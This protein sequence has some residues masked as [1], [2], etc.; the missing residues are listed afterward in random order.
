MALSEMIGAHINSWSEKKNQRVSIDD[1]IDKLL[2]VFAKAREQRNYV[3]KS[4]IA[5]IITA[6]SANYQIT[7]TNYVKFPLPEA[8]EVINSI[9]ANGQE[10]LDSFS[11]K[12]READSLLK[13]EKFSESYDIYS[14][15]SQF[16]K[17]EKIYICCAAI[18]QLM[19]KDKE[20]IDYCERALL[21]NAKSIESLIIL[22]TIY[23][24]AGDNKRALDYLESAYL[25]TSKNGPLLYNLGVL[26]IRLRKTEKAIG[27]FK[28]SILVDNSKSSAYLNLSIC[29]FNKGN[30]DD[31]LSN[32]DMALGI[33][34]G[35]P[36]ALSHK[37]EIQRF[38]GNN[39][40]AIELFKRCLSKEPENFVSLKGLALCNIVEGD[41]IGAAML[42]KLHEN[43]IK[44]SLL[45]TEFS[46]VDIGWT[47]TT[48]IRVLPFDG[49]YLKVVYNELEV[50]VPIPFLLDKIG[51]GLY[52]WGVATYPVIL[53]EYEVDEN[54][55]EACNK[56][57]GDGITKP[58]LL[59]GYVSDQSSYCEINLDFDHFTIFGRAPKSDSQ[60]FKQFKKHYTNEFLLL[61]K[62]AATGD[63]SKFILDK[64]EILH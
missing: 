62:S 22:G 15:I 58:S 45:E 59:K 41:P 35:M 55:H 38:F 31:A 3:K 4:E 1:C 17:S 39:S 18:C 25:N 27:Y 42:I 52:Q 6:Y 9:G 10:L 14:S 48:V 57:K 64:I 5:E 21:L 54:Y 2:S 46:F 13:N 7:S 44:D 32:V 63:S 37:G 33:E 29:Q 20:A 16:I 23:S 53:K 56:I 12:I 43:E 40:D 11:Q 26:H 24:D 28:E 34:P 51:I 50:L 19:N 60:G 49:K 8:Y 36:N 47:K 30:Y 61:L